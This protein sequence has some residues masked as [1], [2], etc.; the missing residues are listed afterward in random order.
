[1]IISTS[2]N[3]QKGIPMKNKTFQKNIIL[4]NFLI[5]ICIASAISLF[6]Y[7]SYRQEVIDT[8]TINSKHRVNTLANNLQT[9]YE[10]ILRLLLICSERQSLFPTSRV[11]DYLDNGSHVLEAIY[12]SD[13]INSLW[14]SSSYQNYISKLMIYNNGFFVQSGISGGNIQDPHVL[15]N[16]PQFYEL[17]EETSRSTQIK[18][19]ENPFTSNYNDP[20]R[21]IPFA[22]PLRYETFSAYQDAWVFISV[23]TALYSDALKTLP[24]D[25]IAYAIAFDNTIIDAI[26]PLPYNISALTASITELPSENGHFTT[27]FDST[28]YI[29]T[30]NKHLPSG[31]LLLEILPV[32]LIQLD[33]TVFLNTAAIVFCYSIAIGLV[34]SFLISKQLGAPIQRLIKRLQLIAKGDFS[35]DSS[36]VTNDE[37]GVIGYQINQMS[38]QINQ[39]L[40]TKIEDERERKTMEINMLQAQ[41]NPHFLYNTLDSIKWIATMQKNSGIV[42]VVTALSSLL[43]NMAKGFNEKVTLAK[44]LEFL[45]SYITIEKIRYLELFDITYNIDNPKLNDAKIIKLT[46][47]PLVENAIFY[48]IEP[49]NKLGL[50]TIAVTSSD[51]D[52]I[53]SVTDNGIGMSKE[54]MDTI[55]L[56]TTHVTKGNMSGIGL[57]NVDRRCKLVYGESYGLT[58]ESEENSFTRITVKIPLEF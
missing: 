34:L 28:E 45:E 58:I 44:E 17:M 10:S 26:N 42:K 38:A 7:I 19:M 11:S 14:A 46:L 52:L 29:V 35:N 31:L 37:F 50:I 5:I 48:G 13:T 4:Y 24:N 8:E 25:S 43:K 16:H 40:E 12:A 18:V 56:D 30:Y 51:S 54:K 3:I 47:Q 6:N 55:F 53:I 36:I 1:M 49:S 33:F 23:S 32:H 39:L 21:I 27:T 57:A 41:I 15:M 20:L 9:T 2:L 22:S